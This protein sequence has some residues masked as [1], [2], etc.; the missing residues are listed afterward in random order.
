MDL[1]VGNEMWFD[2]YPEKPDIAVSAHGKLLVDAA[3]QVGRRHVN[4][5]M[6][7]TGLAPV[8]LSEAAPGLIPGG[9]CPR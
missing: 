9:S 1:G 3:S 4:H 7:K 2:L 6:K 5:R 8:F